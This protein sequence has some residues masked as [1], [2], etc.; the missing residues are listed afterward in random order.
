MLAKILSSQLRRNVASGIVTAGCNAAITF[1]AYPVYIYYLGLEIYGTWLVLAAIMQFALLGDFGV[2]QATI[3]LVSEEHAKGNHVGVQ[4]CISCS[5]FLLG[6]VGAV[7]LC[8]MFLASNTIVNIFGLPLDHSTI[9][10]TYLPW[11]GAVSVYIIL[12][13]VGCSALSGIGRMDLSNYLQSLGRCLGV[14]TSSL[15]L[16]ADFGIQSLLIGTITSCVFVHISSVVMLRRVYGHRLL[17]FESPRRQDIRKVLNF[18]G[19]VFSASLVTLALNPFN[20]LLLCR[21]CGVASVPIYDI[22]FNGAKQMKTL[23]EAALRALIP[24]VSRIAATRPDDL[25]QRVA[26]LNR[27]TLKFL[28]LFSLPGY[29]LVLFMLKPLLVLWVGPEL[30]RPLSPV[31][32]V[33]LI[34]SF[35]SLLSVPSYYMLLGV[36]RV[37]A[38]L[39]ASVLKVVTNFVICLV[40]LAL[41]ETFSPLSLALSVLISMIVTTIYLILERWR[42]FHVSLD[43]LP[44]L[45]ANESF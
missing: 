4:R 6:I 31:M 29:L 25:I 34:G 27:Q 42:F 14:A 5:L 20:K 40:I 21:F 1:I 18:G 44:Q 9:A 23:A 10:R 13:Q 8:L 3:K 39:K 37:H 41:T 11:I 7:L 24:E 17:R 43:R 16:V 26:D 2:S 36:G 35:V 22:A 28:L 30:A 38:I 45:K 15:L 12:S 32:S 33:M 19:G